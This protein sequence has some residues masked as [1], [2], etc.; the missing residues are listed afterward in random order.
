MVTSVTTQHSEKPP[1]FSSPLALLAPRAAVLFPLL[2]LCLLFALNRA[3]FTNAVGTTSLTLP[4][5]TDAADIS[6]NDI[7]SI[8]SLL[9][10]L[11]SKSTFFSLFS[12]A[13][14]KP[15][16]FWNDEN[17]QCVI[18]ACSVDQC[19]DE[20][21][22]AEWRVPCKTG[23]PRPVDTLNDVDRSLTGLAALVGEPPC[24]AVDETAWTARDDMTESGFVDLRR[25]PERYTGFDGPSAF[26][27][28]EAIYRENCF[29]FSAKCSSGICAPDTCKE[30]RILYRLLSGLHASINMHIALAYLMPN[31]QWAVNLDIYRLRVRPFPERIA[32]LRVAHAF[33]LRAVAKAAERLHPA[34]FSYATGNAENDAFTRATIEKILN[35]PTVNPTCEPKTFDESDMFLREDQHLL[36]EFRKAFR[37]ISMIMD[38]VGCEKCRLWGKLQFL[39]LGTAMRILFEQEFP[40]LERNDIIALFN[41]LYKLST[42]VLAVQTLEQQIQMNA[43]LR[44]KA[45]VVLG[46]ALLCILSK[47]AYNSTQKLDTNRDTSKT[48]VAKMKSEASIKHSKS[49][50]GNGSKHQK[51]SK[52]RQAD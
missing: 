1:R 52:L 46:I 35:H 37:N 45:G 15:C 49:L 30:E 2:A 10:H 19:P 17:P 38:C 13:L 40:Q 12:V 23:S 22:P 47:M 44:S 6:L 18:R 4:T 41:L 5:C 50:K 36:P 34:T 29:T 20:E 3:T 43:R 26:R 48:Q 39:G 42:S 27:I 24:L 7:S 32:N 8:K 28:W 16:P 31:K 9:E 11:V 14:D 33:V 21:V 51:T 25:N